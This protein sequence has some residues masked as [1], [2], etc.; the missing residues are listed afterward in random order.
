MFIGRTETPIL[1]SPDVNNWLIGTDLDAGKDWR[2]EEKGM[3]ED[4]MVGR[5]HR[6]DGHEFEQA[7]GVGDEQG[8]LACCSPWDSKGRTRL[9]NWTDWIFDSF[10]HIYVYITNY[11]ECTDWFLREPWLLWFCN[12][13]H[14]C[15]NKYI[16]PQALSTCQLFYISFSLWMPTGTIGVAA[17]LNISIRRA[18]A[19]QKFS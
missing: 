17:L 5:H 12:S 7:L 3:T 1:C 9:S 18:F 8:S 11:T 2:Q 10:F 14:S 4:E 13:L 16:I 19:L 6:L 15:S